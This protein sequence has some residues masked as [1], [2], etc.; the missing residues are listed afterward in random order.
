MAE[1]G[2][3]IRRRRECNSCSQ[4]YTTFERV[5]ELPLVVVKRSGDREPFE[6]SKL[7]SGVRS[8]CKNRP[9]GEPQFEVL[10][11]NVE[12]DLRSQTDATVTTQDIGV[13][14]LERLKG[15]DDVAYVRFASVYKGFE[16]LDDFK[17]EVGLLT[18]S[19]APKR[20]Q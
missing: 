5:E 1:E 8:A 17:R 10:A 6:R 14:V 9:V 19:T 3:A 20:R 13:A 4:R 15:L 7:I 16:D 2:A 18:K 11:Q 12:D